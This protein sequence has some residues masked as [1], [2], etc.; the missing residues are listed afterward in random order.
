MSA[1]VL[2]VLVVAVI[3]Y[4]AAAPDGRTLHATR[5]GGAAVGLAAADGWSALTAGAR[6]RAGAAWR[7]EPTSRWWRRTRKV[8]RGTGGALGATWRAVRAAGRGAQRG[9]RA[10]WE[11]ADRVEHD[12]RVVAA[13]RDYDRAVEAGDAERLARAQQRLTDLGETL[14]TV[15]MTDP[16]GTTDSPGQPAE[17]DAEPGPTEPANGADE[18]P[19]KGDTMA[20]N[21]LSV[22]RTELATPQDLATEARAVL[23]LLNQAAQL[24]GAVSQWGVDLPDRYAAAP[25]GTRHVGHC[26]GEVS[27]VIGTLDPAA[28]ISAAE[29]LAGLQVAIGNIRTLTEQVDSQSATGQ[30]EAFR[31]A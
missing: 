16:E 25:W 7:R 2:A 28:E 29:A 10:G 22:R 13:A 5:A 20:D 3:A 6:A 19:P 23:D 17:G 24:L 1:L 31:T 18:A 30:A 12:R 26:V 9:W 11:Y 4:G 15:P 27:D 14:P 21:P 8:L